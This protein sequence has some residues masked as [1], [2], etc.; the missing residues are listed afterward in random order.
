MT[1]RRLIW[2][3]GD[4]PDDA[5]ERTSPL[6]DLWAAELDAAE[7]HAERYRAMSDAYEGTMGEY[8]CFKTPTPEEREQLLRAKSDEADE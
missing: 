6:V 2:L 5:P 4:P 3:P 7:R 1:R 8:R